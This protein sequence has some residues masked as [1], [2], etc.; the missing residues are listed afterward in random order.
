MTA[1]VVALAGITAGT[2]YPKRFCPHFDLR[3]GAVLQF[4]PTAAVTA[5]VVARTGS[6]RVDWTGEFVFALGWLVVVLSFGAISLLNL[7]IR[8]GSAV[9]VASLFYLTPV[10]TAAMAWP[11]FGERLSAPQLAGMAI[12]VF[13]VWL[14]R[15]G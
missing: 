8:R 10:V 6:W 11:L 12:A 1:A 4:L 2:L 13:G 7:L 5:L 14:A 9:S 3:S 15:R